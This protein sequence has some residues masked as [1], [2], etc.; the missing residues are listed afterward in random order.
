MKQKKGS[1]PTNQS[2]SPKDSA[3]PEGKSPL[4]Q[5]KQ[6]VKEGGKLTAVLPPKAHDPDLDDP[7]LDQNPPPAVR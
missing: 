1:K 5:I 7:T 2:E 4:E 3:P 6:A